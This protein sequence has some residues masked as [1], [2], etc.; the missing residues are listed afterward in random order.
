MDSMKLVPYIENE[1][2]FDYAASS[3]R[4]MLD[5]RMGS[6]RQDALELRHR[7]REIEGC[8]SVLLERYS[9]SAR[10][11]AACEWL[12]DNRYIIQRE[13]PQA[14]SELKNAEAQRIYRGSLML[15]QL[16]RALV[17]AGQGKLTAERCSIFLRGFQSVTVLQR[18]E[19]MLFPGALRAV[20]I[21]AIASC[22]LR[23]RSA[24]ELEPIAEEFAALF[25][26]LRLLGTLDM[27]QIL[28]KADVSGAILA[29]DPTGHYAMMDRET[30][31]EYLSRLSR[32]AKSESLEEHL[33]ARRLIEKAKREQQ[34]IG[35]YLFE[36]KSPVRSALYIAALCL[37]SFF[38]SLF[39]AFSAGSI[40]SALL[41]LL[42]VWSMSKG[43]IDFVLLHFIKPAPLP[44]LEMS[45]GIPEE[46]KSICVISTLLG[47]TDFSKLERLR[48]A[49][50][51]EGENLLFGILADLPASKHEHEPEDEKLIADA[52]AAVD[53]LNKKY[54]GGFY[55]FHRKRSFDGESWSGHE[56]KRGALLELARLLGAEDSC[57]EVHG[58]RHMLPGT[59][60]IISLDADTEIYPGSLSRLIGAA[61]H[62][63]CKAHID[64]KR[65]LVTRGH[66]IIHPRIETELESASATDFAIIFSGGGGSDPYGGLC[67]ELY[68]DAFDNGGFAGKGLI[69]AQALIKCT[70]ARFPEG[71]ILSHDALE[72]A[73]LRGAYMSDAEFSDAFPPN[74]LSYYK[75]QH[76]WIRG[77]WQNAGWMFAK[78][79]SP[80]DR[81]RLFDS[82]RR[83]MTA[84]MTLLAI[85]CGFF[86]SGPGLRL[87]AWAALLSLMQSLLLSLAEQGFSRRK[88]ARLRRH[89]RL[90]TGAGG[91]IVRCFMQLWLLPYEAWVNL[92]AACTALWRML[93]SHKKLLQW[94]TFAQS[95]SGADFAGHI[96]SLWPAVVLG[97]VLMA[98]CP[99]VIGKASGFMWLLSP[100]AAW[101]LALPAY[102]E[103]EL[104]ARDRDMLY[105]AVSDHWLYLRELSGSEDNFLPPDNFQQQP[106]VGTAHRTSPTNIG[107]ALASASALG[108]AGLIKK[109][110]AA[111][112]ISRMLSSLEKMPRYEG[113]YYNWYDTRSLQPLSP[114]HVSTVDSGNMYAGLS[115]TKA[116]LEG[117]GRFELAEKVAAL[118]DGM[119][120]SL[121][122]DPLREL[123]Y[124]SYDPRARRGVG[125]W[126]DLMASEA[127]LTSYLAIAKG[128]VPLKHWRRLSRAQLQKDGYRGL[129]SWTGTMFEY[130][131]PALFLPVYR[132]SLL[133]ESDR[134]CIY[135]QKHRKF[136]GKPWGISE[137]AFYS[138]DAGMNYRYKAHGCPALALK[139]GQEADMVI[140]PYSSFLA[141]CCAPA[142]A[143]RNLRQLKDMGAYGRWGFIEALDFTPARCSRE[144][145]E[146]VRCWMV[147][148]V[149]MSI[150]AAV[151][152]LD[153][154]RV[155]RLFLASGDMA[156]HT[157]LLQEK[158]PDGSALIRRD[159]S[160]VPE[161][162][163]QKLRKPWVLRGGPEDKAPFA[164][165]LSNGAYSLRIKNSGESSSFMGDVCIYGPDSA[166]GLELRL[167]GCPLI[168]AESCTLWELG[169][170]RCRWENNINDIQCTVSRSAAEGETG[171][172]LDLELK[173]RKN[174]HLQLELSF[175]PILAPLR[176]Y[177]SHSA[178]WKLGL[179]AKA[180]DSELVI[181]RLAKG[182]VKEL[183]LCLACSE[184][185]IFSAD[186]GGGLGAL[187]DPFTKATAALRFRE[188]RAK[189][190]FALAVGSSEKE[191]VESARRI[192]F[193]SD[194]SA[195]GM[196]G[197]AAARLGMSQEE[198]GR[199]MELVLPLWENRLCKA[200]KQSE[201][202][203]YGISGDLPIIC[204]DG[205]AAESQWI[206]RAFCLIKSCGM[207]AE[208]VFFND[209]QGEYMQP[210]LRRIENSLSSFG[211][212]ALIGSPG[213]IFTA[214]AEAR[215]I[216]SSRAAV[217]VGA[218][219]QRP[220]PLS[221][222][223]AENARTHGKVPDF[224]WDKHS[225]IYDIKG[226]LPP[227]IWQHI[228]TNGSLG[229]FAADF[230][231]AGL[232]LKNAREMQ[233]IAPP[234]S[235]K[236][237]TANEQI[238]VI[239]EGKAISLFADGDGYPCRV[240]CSP[241]LA[242]WEKHIGS[243]K[244]ESRM[245]IHPA[246][247]ARIITVSGAEGME[248]C[249]DASPRMGQRDSA[250]LCL[251][252]DEGL[253]VFS[254]PESY[255][256]DTAL[257]FASFPAGSWNGDFCPGAVH[258]SLRAEKVSV[259]CCG[260]FEPK[261]IR[262]LTE[263]GQAI[264]AS[265][266]AAAHWQELCCR[267]SLNC[268][269][270]A[271]ENY[272][273]TWAVY[274]TIACRIQGRSSIYQSGGATG[275]RDQ[276]QDCVNLML[277]DPQLSRRQILECCRHQYEEGDVMH[278]WHAHPDGDK[279]VRTR[280]SDDLL[281]LAWALCEYVEA[282]GDVELCRAEVP[283]ISSEE[284]KP[285][286]KD[287]YE[288][289]ALS[290]RSASVLQ[291]AKAA[292][293]CCVRRGFGKHGLPFMGSGD[294][295]D[296]LDKIQGE[297]MWLAW[298]FS[299]CASSFANLLR[300]L[301]EDGAEHYDA[302]AEKLGRAADACHNGQWYLR[303]F[304]PDGEA[305][306]DRDRIDSITQSWAVFCPHSGK[307]KLQGSVS[308]AIEK[309]YDRQR[310]IV[311]LLHP[312]YSAEER[313]VGYISAYGKGFREN[314]GQ[315]THAAVWLAMAAIRLGL[316]DEGFDM[317]RALL[318]ERHDIAVYAAE[319]FV[320]PAD[321]YTAPGRE[322]LAGW[323]WYTGSAGWYFRAVMEELF[324]LKL[325]QGRLYIRPALPERMQS[326]SL[327]WKSPSG[328]VFDILCRDG[329]LFVN[330]ME[331]KGEG[332]EI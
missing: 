121:L 119:D 141:L 229:A 256:R 126:Y 128:D 312:P 319:P 265:R 132:A 329:T 69:D 31:G 298:F 275:F 92:S 147:H 40:V 226:S 249:W 166:G 196:A 107:L 12:L 266:L 328:K 182:D 88:G 50:R 296:G 175:E 74:V 171:E 33:L 83:S 252:F 165:L 112:Y 43:F 96:K 153:K 320:L 144:N 54:G 25:G 201:L 308:A 111:G 28:D 27:E 149:S 10:V 239:H 60:Y 42:P 59:K 123:F 82:L 309:L 189:L 137:S 41:L 136:A 17:Q 46:G 236:D 157:L 152:A 203:K 191:A 116:A 279:G 32:L 225:F 81:F 295:N 34:H 11:P 139:R 120:F 91:A 246:C 230:G 52:K 45:G 18:P 293:D 151:N 103:Q 39:I 200:A 100:A 73:F 181:R 287:R 63:M 130:L 254:N 51:H 185:A 14:Y 204:C 242:K 205:N 57:L 253:P 326:F 218:E 9:E 70:A 179:E 173:S 198:Q 234:R 316:R 77:D 280:C 300:S 274:Q 282:T 330:G 109:N 131:M 125:G 122:F 55:F 263:P 104:S 15:M 210:V 235:I 138:L 211:L 114:A 264:E 243:R 213:G 237:S 321:V 255:Y 168:P 258:M 134:F 281:W 245:F 129:A 102:R 8:H 19:L 162:P 158:L 29:E 188:G 303:A 176:D 227:R 268:A 38:I 124:I 195:G 183:W 16:C 95:G 72:G 215:E 272:I 292:L 323:T 167:D 207:D 87:A 250:G 290:E 209:E 44:R 228:L 325:W 248:L 156:A 118:M 66:A 261:H 322:G 317:L 169:D 241:G 267:V 269:E 48:L 3:A 30:K 231:P 247:D 146:Q 22:A 58:D 219:R 285:G 86:L 108:D 164:A 140:S 187:A 159:Q 20:L 301:G 99:A 113:H 306:G 192:V 271:L 222:A 6:G 148:H 135:A 260:C 332:L 117:W 5:C 53:S 47:G 84:P 314:G 142:A 101:A 284:L 186:S 238:Y 307:E 283:Y 64:E 2:L 68:M 79:L 311:K 180:Q 318:P 7:H 315:Y 97:I 251:C 4:S 297:S 105:T 212:E 244:I 262:L 178:Y 259:L 313:T 277:I 206:T 190:R 223:L 197:A 202:W 273:N 26:S 150:L 36:S 37:I 278:W 302:L 110:E 67:T 270:P 76:R 240:S 61:M 145:G 199:A 80:M 35:F 291:H 220:A 49:S 184:A 163:R 214:A 133:Y 208:L 216:I 257:R 170:E 75:R 276:L 89:T 310:G 289:P 177:M 106:P 221:P 161:R 62:P 1:R 90:L 174:A 324:G 93:V 288:L 23:L 115:V 85:L 56:R 78:E 160:R 155:R 13:Y 127:M 327:G 286:E 299:C 305:I 172:Y 217:H 232:W 193:S 94:Q 331:Y 98:F 24:S 304:F 194:Y 143:A 65:G 21:E 154:G 224:C 294:W 233:L 71:R